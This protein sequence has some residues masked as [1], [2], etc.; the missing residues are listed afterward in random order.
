MVFLPAGTRGLWSSPP[1]GGFKVGEGVALLVVSYF[2][3]LY[4]SERPE[5]LSHLM[6]KILTQ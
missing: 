3:T 1:P 5:V 6:I 4:K 2:I